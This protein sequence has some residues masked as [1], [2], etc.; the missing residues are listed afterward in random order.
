MPPDADSFDLDAYLVRVGYRGP[1]SPT[2]ETLAGLLRAHMDAVPFENLDVLLGRPVRLD[3]RSLQAKLVDARRGGYCFEQVTLFAAVLERT[4]FSPAAHVARVTLMS[5]RPQAARTHMFLKVTLPE[6]SFVVDP[7][8]G[9]LA[10][11]VPVPLAEGRMV[12]FGAEEHAMARDGAWW[13]LRAKRDGAWADAWATTM[14]A[15]Y[16]IDFELGNHYT[17]THPSSPFRSNLMMRVL[18]AQGRVTVMNR[19]VKT[20]QGGAVESRQL[21]DRRA[22]RALLRESFGFD[23]PEVEG[24][25]VPAEPEWA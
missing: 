12:T 17:S 25:R 4:G 2:Y 9:V 15:D 3:L 1:L 22:L 10:P 20:L 13:I 11:R 6:G 18:T 7:G 23:L 19:T 8:F 14:D 24:L 16:P 5:P 21:A